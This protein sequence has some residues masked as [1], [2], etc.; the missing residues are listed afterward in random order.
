MS[1]GVY[2]FLILS[3]LYEISIAVGQFLRYLLPFESKLELC[4]CIHPLALFSSAKGLILS[5]V[6]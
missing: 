2:Q 5:E 3:I 4:T 1:Q 6:H